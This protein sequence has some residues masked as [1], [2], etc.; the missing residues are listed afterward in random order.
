MIVYLA[1]ESKGLPSWAAGCS[2]MTNS[3][4]ECIIPSLQ[5]KKT[6]SR[7]NKMDSVSW[8]VFHGWFFEWCSIDG[9]VDG[10]PQ[11]VFHGWIYGWYS[12]GEI[13]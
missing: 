10:V 6:F 2:S 3:E 1:N 12:V 13:Q 5:K 9:A 7:S 4:Y 8:I 11:M